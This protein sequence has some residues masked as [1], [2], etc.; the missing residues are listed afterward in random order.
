MMSRA[1]E[2]AAGGPFPVRVEAPMCVQATFFEQSDPV[3][4]RTIVHLF[5]GIDS[6]AGHGL[7]KAEVPLREEAVAVHG[8][9]VSFR[10]DAPKRFHIEPGGI[11][12]QVARREGSVEVACPPLEVHAML[13]AEW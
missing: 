5:N 7:P 11:E 9:K 4:K 2:W 13:V 1:I 12:P 3:G 6:A 10:G 8:V